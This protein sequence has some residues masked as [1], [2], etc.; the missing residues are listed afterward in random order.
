ME[1]TDHPDPSAQH[2][3]DPDTAPGAPSPLDQ[4]GNS[5][6]PQTG[7]PCRTCS[8]AAGSAADDAGAAAARYVYALGR[9]ERGSRTSPRKR[10]SPRRADGPTPPAKPIKK[11]S[12]R[13]CPSGTTA[14]WS[15]S[16]VGC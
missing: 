9:I 11:P 15:A 12:T 14:T 13:R 6:S 10:N 7:V 5:A 8:S 1:A 16:C 4:T 3:T 2:A